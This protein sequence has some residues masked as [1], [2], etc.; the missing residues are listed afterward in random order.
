MERKEFFKTCAFACISGVALSTILQSCNTSKMLS[1]PVSNGNLLLDLKEFQIQ[2]KVKISY[3]KYIIIQN[4]ELIFPIC[5]FR[6]SENEFTALNLQCSHQ[7]AELQVF[8]EKLVCP[9]HGSEFNTFGKVENGPATADLRKF[10]IKKENN[11]L[12][13]SLK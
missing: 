5:V 2:K 7:G 13:I 11:Q 4:E 3:R 8:G 6:I 1:L 9:A 12:K 10:P